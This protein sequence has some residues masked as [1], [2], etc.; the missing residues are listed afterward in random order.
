MSDDLLDALRYPTG[1]FSA[2]PHLTHEERLTLIEELERLPAQLRAAVSGLDDDQLDRACRPGGWTVRQVVHH[3]PDSHVNGYI[4]CRKAAT[5]DEPAITLY[6]QAAWADPGALPEDIEPSLMLLDGLHQR[7][8]AF[9]R[10]L[11]ETDF[12]RAYVDPAKGGVTLDTALQLYVWH[13]RHHLAQI[14]N[15]LAGLHG[16][17]VRRALA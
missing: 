11:Q 3:L 16:A 8:G 14:M 15:A 17:L 7:W 2:R 13:G 4:R 10:R 1:R 5:E 12:Q 9:L 6:D